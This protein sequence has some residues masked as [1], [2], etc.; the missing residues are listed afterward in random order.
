[1]R[2]NATA[3]HTLAS[4]GLDQTTALDRPVLQ[5]DRCKDNS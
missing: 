3:S 4:E 2:A 5:A 1:V